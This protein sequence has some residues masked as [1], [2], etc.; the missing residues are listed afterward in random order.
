MTLREYLDSLKDKTVAVIGIGVS[1]TPLLRLLLREKIRVTACDKRDRAAL[2]ALAE[3][4]EKDGCRLQLGEDYLR[5]LDQ[6]VIFRTPGLRPDVPELLAAAERGSEITSEMEVF[7]KVC[8][9]TLIAV[10]GS[11]G[12]TT[13]TTI[14]A[15]LLK[16]AGNTVHVGGNIGNPL[17]CQADEMQAGDYAVLE[18]SSFQLMTMQQSPHIAVV[19]NL[20]PNHLDYHHTME[21]YTQAKTNIFSHQCANDRAVFN[22]DNDITRQLAKTAKCT[23]TMFSRKEKLEDGGVYL[24][25]NAIWLT[26]DIGSREVLPLSMIRIPGVHNIENYMAAIAAVD[27]IVPDK[28]VRAVAQRF[29]GVEHRIEL[30]RELDGVR[31][32]ND[33]IGTSPTRTQACLHSFDQKLVLIAGG[34]DK[35]IP[36]TQFGD[37]VAR[38]VKLLILIG[39]TAQAI[40]QAVEQA[41]SYADSGIEIVMADDLADAVNIARSKARSGDVVVLSPACAAF[42][43]FK[44]FMERGKKFKELVE[45]L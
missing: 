14:I 15:E 4:L 8:P 6:D 10:T 3:E 43:R 16:A 35:H 18:L 32:Y 5:G 40:R 37:E 33:S 2:G 30:V 29:T 25:D 44:N 27:G 11:D 36:F 28:C 17:L 9:C 42:D 23:P 31:Y 12:K 13:T 22:L 39:D 19:T 41:P 21:E 24:R 34:Y 26:N 38:H 45:Q 20:S 1:N 7:F